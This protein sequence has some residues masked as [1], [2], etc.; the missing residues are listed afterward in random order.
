MQLVHK[1]EKTLFVISLVIGS[2]VWLAVIGLTFGIV[3]IYALLGLVFYLFAQSGFIAHLRGNAVELSEEQ[4]P[5]LYRQYRDSCA[6]LGI[7]EVPRAYLLM[8]DGILNALATRF[9][10][11]HYVVVFSSVV[12]ALRSRPEALRFYFGHELGHIVRGHL[13][14]R[15]LLFPASILPLLGT[16]YRRAQEYTCDLHGLATSQS[17]NDALAALALLGTGGERLPQVNIERF[18]AQQSESGGFWMSFHE[19]TNDYPWLSKRLAHIASVSG[20]AQVGQA[21]RRHFFAWFLACFVPRFGVQGGGGLLSVLVLVAIIGILAAIAIPAYQDYTLRTEV[22]QALNFGTGVKAAAGPYIERE[23]AYPD[24]LEDI[25]LPE[26]YET[27]P[28]SLL[29]LT[30]EG[31]EFTLRSNSM[32]LDGQTIVFGAYKEEDGSIGW[33]CHGGTVARKYRPTAC[34]AQ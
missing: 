6:T 13:N 27:G 30:E 18:M 12:E 32:Q 33:S 7:Q 34:R 16:A 26:S 11:R 19:L 28:V 15:W 4:F 9:L 2:I 22:T 14:L 23:G 10:R 21:P 17:P 20:A 3:L 25:G 8:S 29:A 24:S 31:I 1:N 5:D